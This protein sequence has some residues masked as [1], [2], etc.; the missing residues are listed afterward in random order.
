NLHNLDLHN[1][2]LRFGIYTIKYVR[3]YSLFSILYSLFSILYSLFT[4]T[5]WQARRACCHA[6]RP[7]EERSDD[8]WSKLTLYFVARRVTFYGINSP[9]TIN[10]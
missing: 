4:A 2:A 10:L 6:Q 1:V 7:G 3:P 9:I 5:I 8:A